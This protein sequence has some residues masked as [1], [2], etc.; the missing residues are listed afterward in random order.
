MERKRIQNGLKEMVNS[1]IE[2]GMITLSLFALFFMFATCT[3]LFEIIL[4]SVVILL[5]MI[6]GFQVGYEKDD[7]DKD[8]D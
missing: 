5:V 2:L 8:D 4:F 1:I 6:S 3:T 7:N